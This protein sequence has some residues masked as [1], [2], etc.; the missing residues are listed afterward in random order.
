MCDHI[1]EILE[2]I[3]EEVGPCEFEGDNG[4]IIRE[5]WPYLDDEV[6]VAWCDSMDL[7]ERHRPNG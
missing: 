1:D 7:I 5:G 2:A 4:E 3:E 6:G